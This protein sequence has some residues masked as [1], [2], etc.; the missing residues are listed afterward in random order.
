[1]AKKKAVVLQEQYGELAPIGGALRKWESL[2]ARRLALVDGI[3]EVVIEQGQ[4]LKQVK[5]EHGTAAF[6]NFCHQV[7]VKKTQGYTYIKLSEVG[8]ERFLQGLSIRKATAMLPLLEDGDVEIA[9]DRIIFGEGMEIALDKAKE[10]T[11]EQL[12]DLLKTMKALEKKMKAAESL[13]GRQKEVH[14]KEIAQLRDEIMKLEREQR[15]FLIQEGSMDEKLEELGV[16]VDKF[17]KLFHLLSKEEITGEQ[18][19]KF[20]GKMEQLQQILM[21]YKEML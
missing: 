7:G 14:E 5:S 20:E 18:R 15:A 13:T 12:V 2:E 10:M 6:E 3:W 16:A 21:N 8:H 9:G 11:R 19:A 1:M 17:G 4:L